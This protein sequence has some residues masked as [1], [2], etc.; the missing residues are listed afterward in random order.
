MPGSSTIDNRIAN[1]N[2]QTH[3]V[4]RRKRKLVQS[5]KPSEK[6]I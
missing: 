1:R 6:K 4:N 3:E 2:F 5:Q